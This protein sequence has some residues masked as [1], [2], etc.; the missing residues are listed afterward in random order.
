MPDVL[1]GLLSTAAQNDDPKTPAELLL[2]LKAHNGNDAS[3]ALQGPL[4]K[5]DADTKV[6]GSRHDAMRDALP[7]AFREAIIGRFPARA[8]YDALKMAFYR[9]KPETKGT[10]EFDRI[11]RWAAAQAEIADP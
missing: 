1:R 7:W 11:A 10:G 2:F 9:A 5:F 8:A 6:G 4:S 3:G